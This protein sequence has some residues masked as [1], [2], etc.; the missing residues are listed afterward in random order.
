MYG[1]I[2]H[3]YVIESLPNDEKNTGKELYDDIISRHIAL[4]MS[5]I[6]HQF[7]KVKNIDEIDRL[8]KKI[9]NDIKGL[10][11]GVLIHLE[12]HGDEHKKGLFLCNT[13]FLT[14]NWLISHL[15][16]ININLCNNLFLT[17]ATCSGRSL[18]KGLSLHERAPYTAYISAS[19]EV[20]PSEISDQ[21]SNLFDELVKHGNLVKAYEVMESLGTKF[22][23]KDLFSTFE[24]S[25]EFTAQSIRNDSS[26]FDDILSQTKIEWPEN[27]LKIDEKVFK[28]CLINQMMQQVKKKYYYPEC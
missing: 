9:A 17:M 14:W 10:R 4:R 6:G 12:M 15:R 25:F 1:D 27:K 22:F 13:G 21:F 20:L 18:Y 24:D 5:T 19:E 23:F 8:F 2:K 28:E 7:F 3:I 16:E 11:E 26:F